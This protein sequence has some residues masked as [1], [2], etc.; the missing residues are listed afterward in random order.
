MKYFNYNE[1]KN[2]NKFTFNKKTMEIY[3]EGILSVNP[4]IAYITIGVI[5]E[6]YSLKIAQTEN[7]IKS[8]KLIDS[9]LRKGIPNKDIKTKAYTVEK[10]YEYEN[11]KREFKGYK[12]S[13]IL[14]VTIKN[15]EK[16][17]EIIDA[18]IENGANNVSNIEFAISDESLYYR[19]ALVKAVNDAIKK[20]YAVA[21]TIGVILDK[22]PIE[23]VEQ[24]F[25]KTPVYR[26]PG[27]YDEREV[28]PIMP[29]EI[30]IIANIKSIF[31]Y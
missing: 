2:F 20:A 27:L 28:T 6:D 15:I 13:N 11:G 26:Q 14:S 4:D 17:G 24:K 22:V 8:N 25:S 18:S 31:R 9:L 7:I 3:G 30:E 12:V 5:T 23:I 16:L 1:F 21:Y 29:G 19:K 10:V